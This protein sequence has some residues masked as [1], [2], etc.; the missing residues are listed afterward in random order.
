M[1]AVGLIFIIVLLSCC[2]EK[3]IS[4]TS[5]DQVP[6]TWQWESS[7]GGND[8]ACEY[9]S[10]HKYSIIEFTSDGKYKET[11]NDTIYLQTT[12][13]I[14]KY[15]DTFG[16]LILGNNQISRPITVMQNH[17]MITRD[18][19]MDSYSKIK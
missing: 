16:T 5:I 6:G 9:A 12:Y 8:Y 14:I 17:L 11:H 7:C 19:M 2:S 4:V 13:S 15:D 3:T 18:E 10:K 1:K